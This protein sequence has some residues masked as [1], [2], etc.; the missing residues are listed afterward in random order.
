VLKLPA[1]RVEADSR[2]GLKNALLNQ[3]KD[4]EVVLLS[5][6]MSTECSS[7]VTA[8]LTG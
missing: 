1:Y 5:L 3:V 7:E 2:A 6:P 4:A 8:L